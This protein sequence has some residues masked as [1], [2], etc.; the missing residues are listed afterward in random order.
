L[1]DTSQENGTSGIYLFQYLVVMFQNLAMQQ[2]GKLINP[3]TNKLERDLLQARITIDMIRMIKEKTAGNLSEEE[4]GFID[5]V[6]L[7]LQMNYIDEAKRDEE[8]QL[9][10]AKEAAGDEGQLEAHDGS[11][12]EPPPRR[13][14]GAGAGGDAR[15]AESSAS[16][17]KKAVKAPQRKKAKRKKKKVE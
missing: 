5:H 4:Q 11:A 2:M 15:R 17:R 16:K 7:D 1:E 10:E 8:E 3:I 13:D 9:G 12:E 14:V 6:L